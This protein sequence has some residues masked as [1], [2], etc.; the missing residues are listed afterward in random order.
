MKTQRLKT[1]AKEVFSLC[2]E[3]YNLQKGMN[4]ALMC[5]M[6]YR[7]GLIHK[8]PLSSSLQLKL[9]LTEGRYDQDTGLNSSWF[10]TFWV[11]LIS[12]TDGRFCQ[13]SIIVPKY[14]PSC[15]SLLTKHSVAVQKKLDLLS[16]LW[17]LG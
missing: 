1:P 3:R 12:I 4:A 16:W 17:V 14:M 8:H 10:Q 15:V 7:I 2:S 5:H 9:T 11:G 6:T 13:S